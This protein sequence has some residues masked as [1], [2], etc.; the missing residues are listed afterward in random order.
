MN[1]ERNLRVQELFLAALEIPNSG[2]DKWL[3]QQ[4]GTDVILRRELQDLLTA[5]SPS[6]DP[7]EAGIG[8]L[9]AGDQ[10]SVECPRCRAVCEIDAFVNNG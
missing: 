8:Q 5:D 10:L 6:H 4:C 7:L 1:E 2:R 3:V 9:V